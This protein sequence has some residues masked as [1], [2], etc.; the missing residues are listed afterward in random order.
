MVL[1]KVRVC[2]AKSFRFKHKKNQQSINR[3]FR[4][5]Q[6]VTKEAKIEIL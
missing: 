3:S 4:E 2:I 6:I 5:V 1:L